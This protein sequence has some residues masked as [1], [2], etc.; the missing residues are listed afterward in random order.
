MSKG[1]NINRW[2]IYEMWEIYGNGLSKGYFG[3][4]IEDVSMEME[5][6]I[7]RWMGEELGFMGGYDYR[8]MVE[9]DFWVEE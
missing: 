2:S 9:G 6:V 1:E 5:F 8:K 7:G 4:E 3:F